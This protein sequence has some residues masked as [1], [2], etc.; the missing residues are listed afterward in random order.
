MHKHKKA[1]SNSQQNEKISIFLLNGV[2]FRLNTIKRTLFM[3]LFNSPQRLARL[4][5]KLFVKFLFALSR[6][7]RSTA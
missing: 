7:R 4:H 1:G 6:N 5:K 2:K 3:L